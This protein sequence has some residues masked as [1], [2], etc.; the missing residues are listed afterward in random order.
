M[1]DKQTV[2]ADLA[3]AAN[4]LHAS[5]AGHPNVVK[6][7]EAAISHLNADALPELPTPVATPSVDKPKNPPMATT[8]KPP[9]KTLPDSYASNE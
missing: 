7:I 8:T 3:A 6:A 5:A 1:S 4:E 2:I 9:S